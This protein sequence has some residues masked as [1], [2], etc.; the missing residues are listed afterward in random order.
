MEGI[1]KT[2]N[3]KIV[4]WNCNFINNKFEEFTIFLLKYKPDMKQKL[5]KLTQIIYSITFKIIHLFKNIEIITKMEDE[6]L[7]WL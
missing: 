1:N 3:I 7:R 2:K 5:M 6:V 4:H